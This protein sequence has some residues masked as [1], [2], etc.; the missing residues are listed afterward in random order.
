MCTTWSTTGKFV[1]WQWERSQSPTIKTTKGFHLT[2]LDSRQ[3]ILE[4]SYSKMICMCNISSTVTPLT[5]G[6]CFS[7]MD[8]GTWSW[9]LW[10]PALTFQSLSWCSFPSSL[11]LS[12]NSTIG[13]CE[14]MTLMHNARLGKVMN[15]DAS[16][17][18]R[19]R[20]RL[21]PRVNTHISEQ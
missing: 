10:N 12:K 16:S 15:N 7:K 2:F 4:I 9:A 5:A 18:V 19:K 11:T 8:A 3:N 13:E 14:F 6:W 21:S 20:Q 1:Y 17:F